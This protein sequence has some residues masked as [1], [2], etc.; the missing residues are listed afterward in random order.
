[1]LDFARPHA[2]HPLRQLAHLQAVQIWLHRFIAAQH[3]FLRTR[4]ARVHI[5]RATEIEAE[6]AKEGGTFAAFFAAHTHGWRD[7]TLVLGDDDKPAP[8]SAEALA[9]A[10]AVPGFA[11]AAY[12][13]YLAQVG[14]RQ[15]NSLKPRA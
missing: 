4:G 10:M 1:M 14:V 6:Q 8:Y 7:Q 15:K 11:V 3:S 9:C 2:T 5:L 13:A 12:Q